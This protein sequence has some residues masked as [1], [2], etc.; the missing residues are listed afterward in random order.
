M[1][2]EEMDGVG[3]A[4][5]YFSVRFG[6]WGVFVFDSGDENDDEGTGNGLAGVISSL[7]PGGIGGSLFV[8]GD[9]EA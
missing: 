9:F 8:V 2:G 4:G 7:L 6:V 1:M 3:I 5:R